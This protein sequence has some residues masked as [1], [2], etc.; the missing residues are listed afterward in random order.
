MCRRESRLLETGG[1][2]NDKSVNI[3]GLPNPAFSDRF[4]FNFVNEYYGGHRT[5]HREAVD[6]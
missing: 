1:G 4:F 3:H 6:F 5:S 2:G